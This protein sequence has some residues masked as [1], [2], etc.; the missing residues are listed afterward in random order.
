[1]TEPVS[2]VTRMDKEDQE[3]EQ[4]TVEQSVAQTG[5]QEALRPDEQLVQMQQSGVSKSELLKFINDNPEATRGAEASR[6]VND[7]IQDMT[8]A[9]QIEF[10]NAHPNW[11][12]RSQQEETIKNIQSEVDEL[13]QLEG[14]EQFNKA[15]ELGLVPSGSRY[16]PTTG[17]Y[18]TPGQLVQIEGSE[19]A[20]EEWAKELIDTAR[21]RQQALNT[22]SE[23][24]TEGGYDLTTAIREGHIED[25]RRAEELGLFNPLDVVEAQSSA[26]MVGGRTYAAT[27][28]EDYAVEGGYDIGRFLSENP[29]EESTLRIAGFTQEQIDTAK[30]KIQPQDMS[31]AA[32]YMAGLEKVEQ[33]SQPDY[34]PTVEEYKAANPDMTV[35]EL[36]NSYREKYGNY[37]QAYT[38]QSYPGGNSQYIYENVPTSLISTPSYV[39]EEAQIGH[40]SYVAQYLGAIESA[41]FQPTE[42][43]KM[44]AS[45]DYYRRYGAV[46]GITTQ[47]IG[48][49]TRA[50]F[51]AARVLEPEY[52]FRDI[53][54]SEW[55]WTI[56]NVLLTTS[57]Y[58]LPPLYRATIG[59]LTPKPQA[60]TYPV[61]SDPLGI[62]Q[63]TG[64][65][66]KVPVSQAFSVDDMGGAL[67]QVKYPPAFY[68]V[69]SGT[70]L[71]A[72]APY[73]APIPPATGV[74]IPAGMIPGKG[75]ILWSS[76]GLQPVMFTGGGRPIPV[77]VL[78]TMTGSSVAIPSTATMTPEQLAKIYGLP[79][80]QAGMMYVLTPDGKIVQ[81]SPTPRPLATPIPVPTNTPGLAPDPLAPTIPAPS[82]IPTIAPSPVT[83]PL[84]T[85]T[86]TPTATPTPTP[87]SVTTPIPS[88]SPIPQPTPQP[89]PSPQPTPALQPSAYPM[90]TPT[91]TPTMIGTPTITAPPIVPSQTPGIPFVM[92]IIRSVSESPTRQP[93][94]QGSVTWRQ[95][96]LQRGRVNVGVWK[97]IPPPWDQNKPVTI[98]N[99][100]LGAKVGGRTP[101]ETIQVIGRSRRYKIP[102]EITIDMGWADVTII[103]G[104]EIYF[105]SGGEETDFGTRISSTTEGMSVDEGINRVRRE[106]M[107][108]EEQTQV[109]TP[110]YQPVEAK[111]EDD[112]GMEDLFDPGEEDDM[113]DIVE[114]DEEDIMGG[115]EDMSDLVNVSQEDVMG[116]K[117]K[118]KTKVRRTNRR[119]LPPPTSLGGVGY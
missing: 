119:Y 99:P 14:E 97:Y 79:M 33:M 75:M 9:Q 89:Q 59:R 91:P 20:R 82:T 72:S 17:G 41:G 105:A 81:V 25:I 24:E 96:E 86:P 108:E 31:M 69:Y 44:Q 54:G 55:A 78:P 113:E 112:S 12:R 5:E 107:E 100:P 92:P 118:K 46:S 47:A 23:Y 36:V 28:I 4:P 67:L 109:I 111:E 93:I 62:P 56:A 61:V 49:A 39:P 76:E 102:K 68:E 48:M 11:A 37:E 65:T 52:A 116:T 88:P 83:T 35:G 18:Y 22:L 16:D 8:V 77:K 60:I 1:M 53:S 13:R 19:Q 30:T 80:L 114:V 115:D 34:I 43:M 51:P 87:I 84:P 103:D 45:N 38:Y 15:V 57:P 95:G 2:R 70:P 74:A 26:A 64:L 29:N 66:Y 21:A 85:T 98:Y 63:T 50:G 7:L 94:P 101:A 73:T 71:S 27:R 32:G 58:W 106:P 40:D 6:I 110:A 104:K 3:V 10:Y 42:D 117:P 90:P